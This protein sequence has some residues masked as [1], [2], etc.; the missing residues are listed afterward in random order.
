M[1]LASCE[2]LEHCAKGFGFGYSQVNLDTRLHHHTG[3]F[4]AVNQHIF[5]HWQGDQRV[6]HRFG[7][8][9]CADQVNVTDG[10]FPASQ[11]ADGE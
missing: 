3:L 8:R 7:V 9:G 4:G 1:L 10:L 5:N 11:A 2:I 6:T